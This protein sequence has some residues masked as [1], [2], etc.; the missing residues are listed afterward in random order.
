MFGELLFR[1]IIL[2]LVYFRFVRVN[3]AVRAEDVKKTE[4]LDWTITISDGCA[5]TGRFVHKI[6][7]T[8]FSQICDLHLRQI[9]CFNTCP[10]LLK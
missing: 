2:K 1:I 8:G 5:W 10:M 3:V 6:L 4:Q 9:Y 7:K